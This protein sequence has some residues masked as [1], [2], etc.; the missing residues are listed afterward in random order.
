MIILNFNRSNFYRLYSF[1]P[2]LY[3]I[4]YIKDTLNR[5]DIIYQSLF[6]PSLKLNTISDTVKEAVNQ[7]S[8][9]L[10]KSY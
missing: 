3:Y 10:T 6:L 9:Y 5:S 2:L 4:D 8:R 7:T 1:S